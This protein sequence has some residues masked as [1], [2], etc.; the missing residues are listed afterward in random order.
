M[1]KKYELYMKNQKGSSEYSAAAIL[2]DGKITIKKGSKINKK[3]AN[4]S[5]FK[6]N[7]KAQAKRDEKGLYDENGIL[8]Q[9][10]QF[11]SPSTAGQFV[12]GY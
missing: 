5:T 8:L 6:L 11:D 7:A 3:I 10:V 12:C 4:S 2:E 9:D 1:S